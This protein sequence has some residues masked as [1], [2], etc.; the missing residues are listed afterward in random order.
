MKAYSL[1]LKKKIVEAVKKG[2]SKARPLNAS[3]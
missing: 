3:V 1:D 2:V